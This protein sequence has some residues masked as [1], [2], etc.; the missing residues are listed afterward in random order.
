[1]DEQPKDSL[2]EEQLRVVIARAIELD[3]QRITTSTDELRVIATEIG[4]SPES[5]DAALR[6]YARNVEPTVRKGST[7]A[8]SAVVAAGVPLGIAAGMLLGTASPFA[9]LAALG[10]VAIGLVAS[11]ALV[12][13][14]GTN[15]TL[16]SFQLRNFLLWGAMTIGGAVTVGLFGSGPI[17]IPGIIVGWGLRSWIASS[18][19]GSAAVIAVRRAVT[20]PP[21]GD[22]STAPA[23]SSVRTRLHHATK[24]ITDWL[25]RLVRRGTV[26]CAPSSDDH[27][28][29]PRF[30]QSVSA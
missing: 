13:V 21:T 23:T 10:L 20:P 27:A 17:A 9:P 5:V 24:R 16:R 11:G 12:V 25:A 26:V 18:I 28:H 8:A 2:S 30:V 29:R 22:D 6:E 7:R 1:M 3:A 4:I 14:Q 19:L 15:A